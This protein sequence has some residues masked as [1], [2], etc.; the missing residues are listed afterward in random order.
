MIGSKKD[1][2]KI[3]GLL[4]LAFIFSLFISVNGYSQGVK[5]NILTG[6]NSLTINDMKARLTFLGSDAL[7]GRESGKQGSFVAAGYIASEFA[8]IGL[9]PAGDKGYFQSV[10]LE[11][12]GIDI[13]N[14]FAAITVNGKE[15]NLELFTDFIPSTGKTEGK[16]PVVFAGYGLDL[17]A[18]KSYTGI[19]VK[20]KIVLVLSH[21]PGE[22]VN[23]K[24]PEEL[25]DLNTRWYDAERKNGGLNYKANIAQKAGAAGIIMVENPGMEHFRTFEKVATNIRR[26]SSGSTLRLGKSG[27][28]VK[29]FPSLIISNE[30][31]V[32]I[33]SATGSGLEDLKNSIVT[34]GKPASGQIENVEIQFSSGSK[35]VNE[36]NVVGILKGSDPA[37]SGEYIVVGAHF[38]H[39]GIKNGRIYN[40][41]DD[42]ASGTVGVIEL[43]EAF[44]LNPEKPKRSMIF[45]AFTAEEKGLL[46]S[47]YYVENPVKPLDKTVAMF[48]LDMI[49]R[50]EDTKNMNKRFRSA[51]GIKPPFKGPEE[52]DHMVNIIGT[53]FCPA[54]KELVESKNKDIRL[55]LMYHYDESYFIRGSD[56]YPFLEKDI[57]AVFFFT[58]PHADLHQPTDDVDKSDFVKMQKICRLVYLSMWEMANTGT[59][60]VVTRN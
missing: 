13:K 14:S 34:T 47:T 51:F 28:S 2:R 23:E 25:E 59:K 12:A 57:P 38:D 41:T 20:G 26:Y 5:K 50:D 6:Y 27:G 29:K 52:N 54:L 45:I 21:F 60:P 43:A 7:E 58:G 53:K 16:L 40:G 39:E 11:R 22:V 15:I 1:Y 35:Q 18:Y 17:P 30:T 9:E 56:H 24:F 4:S 10:P 33:I 49:S 42:D 3:T 48:Q 32:K 8:R 44:K 55:D 31:A 37:L 36:Q 19:D 46:G